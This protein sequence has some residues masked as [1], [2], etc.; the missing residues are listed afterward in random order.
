MDELRKTVLALAE[1]AQIIERQMI[2]WGDP[3]SKAQL[4]GVAKR[5]GSLAAKPQSPADGH[6]HL[7]GREGR[8]LA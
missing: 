6:G 4:R 3:P 8:G 7:V 5:R 2:A 1:E